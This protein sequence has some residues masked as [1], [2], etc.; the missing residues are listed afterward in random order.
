[1]GDAQPRVQPSPDGSGAVSLNAQRSRGQ[2]AANAF[3]WHRGRRG[4]GAAGFAGFQS[5]AP[6]QG[7]ASWWPRRLGSTPATPPALPGACDAQRGQ[8]A[9]EP[10]ARR[11]ASPASLPS[12]AHQLL[13][14]EPNFC[15]GL[16]L[17]EPEWLKAL[18]RVAAGAAPPRG[19]DLAA[20]ALVLVHLGG[21]RL[22]SRQRHTAPARH[23]S[24]W[25]LRAPGLLGRAGALGASAPPRTPCGQLGGILSLREGW[26][27]ERGRR[28]PVGVCR[29][30]WAERSEARSTRPGAYIVG[31]GGW[32]LFA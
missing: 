22:A 30:P 4:C 29:R 31:L 9:A 12:P 15:C 26:R 14:R 10:T 19:D 32:V 6:E 11:P 16:G 2:R 8:A 23:V 28:H 18:S 3:P 1:M 24:K 20:V 5:L 25:I 21:C 17:A 27:L 13:P 7:R